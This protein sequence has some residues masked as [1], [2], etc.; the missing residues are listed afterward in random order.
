MVRIVFLPLLWVPLLPHG[1]AGDGSYDDNCY[2]PKNDYGRKD[3]DRVTHV[4]SLEGRVVETQ[5]RQLDE[6][7]AYSV[8]DR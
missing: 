8:D 6:A 4:S 7:N 2:R 3:V 1:I 5:D